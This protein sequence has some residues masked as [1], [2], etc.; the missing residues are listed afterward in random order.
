VL[1][2]LSYISSLS[3]P[4]PPPQSL[5]RET[6]IEPATNSLEGCDSTTELLPLPCLPRSLASLGISPAGSRFA[7]RPHNGSTWK[8]VTL[9]LSY[10][11]LPLTPNP[12]YLLSGNDACFFLK[13]QIFT[14]KSAK[15]AIATNRK[16]SSTNVVQA[17]IASTT[18]IAIAGQNLFINS[19]AAFGC[20]QKLVHRG[21]FEPP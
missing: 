14:A 21:G 4:Y 13:T 16:R 17:S 15:T 1:Y 9:P 19:H 8:A 6:G 3:K 7:H 10:S 2:Q 20:I 11:R 5:E 18:N 12:L